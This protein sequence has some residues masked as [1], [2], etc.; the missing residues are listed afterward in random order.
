[1]PAEEPAAP[2]VVQPAVPERPPREWPRTG[3]TPSEWPRVSKVHQQCPRCG[4]IQSYLLKTYEDKGDKREARKCRKCLH[5]F[6]VEWPSDGPQAAHIID[7]T[8]ER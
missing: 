4:S 8:R 7:R 6:I 1:L 5:G 2:A 3:L